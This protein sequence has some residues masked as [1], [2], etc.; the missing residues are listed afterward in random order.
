MGGG[1]SPRHE[2]VHGG[3]ALINNDVQTVL[4]DAYQG[5]LCSC[6]CKQ[7]LKQQSLYC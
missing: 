7:W 6:M 4:Y 1:S 5:S 2:E 3:A